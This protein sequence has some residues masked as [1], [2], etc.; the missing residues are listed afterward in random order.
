VFDGQANKNR[1]ELQ[2]KSGFY[3]KNPKKTAF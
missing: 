1:V 3:L 2:K